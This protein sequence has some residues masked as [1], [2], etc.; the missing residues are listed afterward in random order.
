VSA[1]QYVRAWSETNTSRS[2]IIRHRPFTPGPVPPAHHEPSL[3]SSRTDIQGPGPK[4]AMK[5]RPRSPGGKPITLV[6]PGR[7]TL[8]SSVPSPFC[9][10]PFC[11]L[12]SPDFALRPVSST[13]PASFTQHNLSLAEPAPSLRRKLPIDGAKLPLHRRNAP[14]SH[15]L[16][17][18]TAL[19]RV[20]VV[21]H[22]VTAP[23]PL[24]SSTK[25]QAQKLI[26]GG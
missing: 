10:T 4:S 5:V 15:Q 16:E 20:S 25:A 21:N 9:S 8:R 18:P 6:W 7:P 26:T 23:R 11:R 19:V 17:A 22:H 14:S 24:A 12:N 3:S 13:T 2:V 1:G